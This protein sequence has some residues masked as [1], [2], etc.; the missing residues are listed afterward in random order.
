MDIF[1]SQ[2]NEE[3][4]QQ[5]SSWQ[6][7][8]KNIEEGKKRD[9]IRRL[10]GLSSLF[11]DSESDYDLDNIIFYNY[12]EDEECE[13]AYNKVTSNTIKD[14]IAR[15]H[16]KCVLQNVDLMFLVEIDSLMSEVSDEKIQI[17][18]NN[19][20]KDVCNNVVNDS[21]AYR[22]EE[23]WNSSDGAYKKILSSD[24]ESILS[25]IDAYNVITDKYVQYKKFSLFEGTSLDYEL[26]DSQEFLNEFKIKYP[27]LAERL[28]CSICNQDGSYWLANEFENAQ[29]IEAFL[30]VSDVEIRKNLYSTM[31]KNMR[32]SDEEVEKL[33]KI[34]SKYNV[35]VFPSTMANNLD[36]LETIEKELECWKNASN[37]EAKLPNIINLNT[38]QEGY[39]R[40]TVGSADLFENIINLDF[41]SKNIKSILRHEV[42]HINDKRPNMEDCVDL[43]ND[44]FATKIVEGKKVIDFD[45]CKYREELLKAGISIYD[46]KYAYTN[47]TEFVAVVAEG[48][49][50]RYSPE[51]KDVLLKLGIPAYV[52]D[53]KGLDNVVEHYANSAEIVL[54]DY[55][56]EKDFNKLVY[57]RE[58]IATERY[59]CFANMMKSIISGESLDSLFSECFENLEDEEIDDI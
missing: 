36:V 37:G 38:I 16:N 23:F 51:F 8:E 54:S 26:V 43:L 33:D 21:Y 28:K 3:E 9:E 31:I 17:Y 7:I 25:V 27:D 55:P 45:R 52:W 35:M 30:A 15:L 41:R 6:I 58:K 19:A 46:I 4:E 47:R 42:M 13:K 11:D 18:V 49:V 40:N 57:L 14:L 48:D 50:A 22:S 39:L 32:L 12:V 20:L 10:Y 2:S 59:E 29:K 44:I 34:Y 53:L 1:K 56:D 24:L 5:L